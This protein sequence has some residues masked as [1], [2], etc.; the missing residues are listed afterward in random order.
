VATR[1]VK[2]AGG[3]YSSLSAWEAGEQANLTGAGPAVAECYAFADTANVV[4]NGWTTTAAD[5]VQIVAAAGEGHAGVW[6]AGK[7]TLSVGA[8]TTIALTVNED[9][10]RVEGIQI[11]HTH[12]TSASRRPGVSVSGTA[13]AASSDVRLDRLLIRNA[14]QG[15]VATSGNVSVGSGKVTLRNC[16]LY[17]GQSNGLYSLFTTNAPT[18]NADN[19]TFAG[20]ASHGANRNNG[21]VTLRNC[22]A[23]ANVTDDYTGTITRTTCAHSTAT[24]F[25]GSTASVAHSTA[26]FV[27]VTGGSEDYHLVTGSAL[28]DAGTDLSG[29]F[30]VDVDGATRSAPW[31]IGADEFAGAAGGHPTWKRF[32]GVAFAARGNP[33]V[34]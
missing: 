12:A 33:G 27:S 24:V 18:V 6:D 22:Y 21:T 14:G 13:A 3:D 25:A 15:G 34:W 9:F 16:V 31:D 26:T 5:Y 4:V 19:C 20:N 7:Y 28:V 8:V 2:S 32:G 1:T 29:D 17:G 30:T 11:E 10:V 23:G